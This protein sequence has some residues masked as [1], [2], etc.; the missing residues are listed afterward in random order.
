MAWT[1]ALPSGKYR[2]LY[3]TTSGQKRSVGTYPHKEKA[4]A[5]AME[6]EE[7][8]RL[9]GWRDPRAAAR[10]WG[11]WEAKWW[12]ARTS[13]DSTRRADVSLLKNHITPHW[14]DVP[15]AE[16]SRFAVREWIG[17][18]RGK[19]LADSTVARCVRVFSASLTAAMDAEILTVNPCFNQNVSPAEEETM[20]FYTHKE[21]RKAMRNLKDRPRDRAIV[22]LLVGSGIRWGE[23]IG[24]KG[25]YVDLK[26][27]LIRIQWTRDQV[28]G[29]PKKYPKGRAARTVP[30]PKW[31]AKEIKPFVKA[32]G[33]DGL[34]FPLWGSSTWNK[35]VWSVYGPG[36]RPHDLRHTYA[37]W[38]L[39]AGVPLAEVSKLLGHHSQRVTERYAHLVESRSDVIEGAIG[40]FSF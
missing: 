25:K 15:L 31:V 10:T 3:R 27:N 2:G 4:L 21:I 8:A 7:A 40:D 33:G 28:T 24:L 12:A 16:I 5:K 20:R 38:M 13:E 37:S 29:K 39:Q 23:M 32:A 17:I 1:E 26:K 22:A 36:G 9:P 34:V 30:I 35:A 11:D 14:G 18:L 19:G 6:A